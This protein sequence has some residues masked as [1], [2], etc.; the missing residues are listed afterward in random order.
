MRNH[1]EYVENDEDSENNEE[2]EDEGIVLEIGQASAEARHLFSTDVTLKWRV[3]RI[4]LLL[5]NHCPFHIRDPLLFR[6]PSYFLPIHH[7]Y[8]PFSF[9][10]LRRLRSVAQ[11]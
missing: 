9:M 5:I 1:D 11:R 10:H 2:V 8:A 3:L 6:T 7:L 4:D